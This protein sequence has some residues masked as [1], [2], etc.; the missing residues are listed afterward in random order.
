MEFLLQLSQNYP[1]P[2]WAAVWALIL[3]LVWFLTG[4]LVKVIR[5]VDRTNDT[6]NAFAKVSSSLESINQKNDRL[7]EKYAF[8][9]SNFDHLDKKQSLLIEK[10][11]SLVNVLSEKKA[12]KTPTLFSVNSPIN[13]TEGGQ[14]LVADLGWKTVMADE[15]YKKTLF[16][17]LDKIHL[18][19]RFDVEK[20]CIVILSEYS[21][22]P[23]ES[24][25][26]PIKKYLYEHA[27]ID[28]TEALT[29][30]AIYL[31]D[32]YL[33]AHPEISE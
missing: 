13:L 30:C 11:N 8:L 27:N 22:S 1:I 3:N 10:F 7:N 19:T 28:D 16:E 32:A 26:T 4:L 33:A 5:F 12:I 18:T 25:Y 9:T 31:R 15:A 2:T 23:K 20:Y 14:Q 24:P 17:T 29:A 21:G 6:C